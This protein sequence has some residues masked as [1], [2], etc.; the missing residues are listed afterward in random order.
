MSCH[1][2]QG[3]AG[4]PRHLYDA[5]LEDAGARDRMGIGGV[6]LPHGEIASPAKAGA[7]DRDA[8]R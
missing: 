8:M 1:Q 2:F 3:R 6:R 4:F 5:H 7:E